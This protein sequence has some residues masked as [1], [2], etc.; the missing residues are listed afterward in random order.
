MGAIAPLTWVL[1]TGAIVVLVATAIVG[2]RERR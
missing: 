2:I 1:L